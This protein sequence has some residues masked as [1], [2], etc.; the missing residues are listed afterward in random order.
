MILHYGDMIDGNCLVKIISTVRP[1]EVYNLAAQSHVKVVTTQLG[2]KIWSCDAWSVVISTINC[3]NLKYFSQFKNRFL[4]SKRW[5]WMLHYTWSTL[6]P[7]CGP[8]T[9]WNVNSISTELFI[10]QIA[11]CLANSNF[12]A[13]QYHFV[14]IHFPCQ[15]LF[16]PN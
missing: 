14:K 6:L 13:N 5:R 9:N 15:D 10:S 1:S 11:A 2:I 16:W 8:T 4:Y 12:A 7:T 3:L